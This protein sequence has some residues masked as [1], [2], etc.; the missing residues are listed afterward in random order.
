MSQMTGIERVGRILKRQ[1]VDRI[2]VCEAF[3]TETI[4]AGR[5]KG[6][7]LPTSRR[8]RISTSIWRTSIRFA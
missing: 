6:T 3:W 2:A 7:C 5:P 1:K 8:S 4:P